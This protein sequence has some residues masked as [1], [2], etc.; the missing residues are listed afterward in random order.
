[1]AAALSRFGAPEN[2]GVATL[3]AESGEVACAPRNFSSW[4]VQSD[5]LVVVGVLL[6]EFLFVFGSAHLDEH[7]S[8][9]ATYG[10]TRL[11]DGRNKVLDETTKFRNPARMLDTDSLILV[12]SQAAAAAESRELPVNCTWN[13]MQLSV[14]VF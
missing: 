3:L 10:T 1:M 9:R 7:A 13:P 14:S 6:V 4:S 11:S 12:C 2:D 5:V 8:T